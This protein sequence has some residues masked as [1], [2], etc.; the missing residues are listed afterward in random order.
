VEIQAREDPLT[1]SGPVVGKLAGESLTFIRRRD[2]LFLSRCGVQCSD[3]EGRSRAGGPVPIDDASA[4][5]GPTAREMD[6]R[7]PPSALLAGL[8]LVDGQLAL[9]AVGERLLDEEVPA[10][11]PGRARGSTRTCWRPSSGTR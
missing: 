11:A 4:I 10:K 2:L 9:V 5:R 6:R 3:R 1:I 8:C 7:N